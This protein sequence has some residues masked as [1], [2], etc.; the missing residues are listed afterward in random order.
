MCNVKTLA[1]LV[2]FE[3][4]TKSLEHSCS[5]PLSYSRSE[6]LF[7]DELGLDATTRKT[8]SMFKPTWKIF[9]NVFALGLILELSD[10]GCMACGTTT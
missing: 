3:P 2:G 4:T 6:L 10:D 9:L 8:F 1:R 5:D 7:N